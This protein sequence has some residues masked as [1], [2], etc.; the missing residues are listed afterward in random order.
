MP[1]LMKPQVRGS[2]F[3]PENRPFTAVKALHLQCAGMSV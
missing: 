2:P 1:G 3:T